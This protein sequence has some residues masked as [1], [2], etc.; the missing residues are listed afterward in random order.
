[1][2]RSALAA[3]LAALALLT[4]TATAA[5]MPAGYVELE[6]IVV[7]NTHSPQDANGTPTVTSFAAGVEYW[8][9][10]S[11]VI[12]QT[13]VLG[14]GAT[15]HRWA[16]A[17]TTLE[18]NGAGGPA[19]NLVMQGVAAFGVVG[20]SSVDPR[21]DHRYE[22]RLPQ[23][24]PGP[25]RFAF[26]GGE[27][28]QQPDFTC[29]GSFTVTVYGPRPT[30]SVTALTG[31]VEAQLGGA[32]W[33]PATRATR[34]GAGDKLHTGF[35]AQATLRFP[36]GSTLTLGPM[37]MLVVDQLGAR[38]RLRLIN[39]E[40]KVQVV[41]PAGGPADFIVKTPTTTTSIRGTVFTMLVDAG[42]TIVTVREGTVT[43]DPVRG[44]PVDVPAGSETQATATTAGPL[45]PPGRAGAPA[46]SVGPRAARALVAQAAAAGLRACG[47][48]VASMSLKA[49][50]TGWNATARLTGPKARGA[51]TWRIT[52]R[53]VTAVNALAKRVAAR[54]R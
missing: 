47:S 9:V 29:T 12:D 7:E 53:K 37:S 17:F 6:T 36:D 18:D 31:R 2:H 3:L 11:G 48:N 19:L 1:M 26:N 50:R 51:A 39:G 25:S 44:E 46:G 42:S 27:Q 43:V 5:A 14:S 30:A 33:Q 32:A 21:A 20:D 15:V 38:T 34:L 13:I 8:A 4:S 45:V 22:V 52:A 24:R 10:V 23:Y 49:T 41:R 54:C 35:R 40:V 28:C 16:D